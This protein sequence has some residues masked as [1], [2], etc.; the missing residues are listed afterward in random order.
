MWPAERKPA[1]PANIEFQF[2]PYRSFSS[3]T[4]IIAPGS[5]HCTVLCYE[6]GFA[7]TKAL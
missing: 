6:P 7:T 2:Y 5:L 3:Y 1:H 4:E